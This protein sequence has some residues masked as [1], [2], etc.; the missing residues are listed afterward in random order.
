[1]KIAG[2]F[3]F[4]FYNRG[5]R[6]SRSHRM[7]LKG[8]RRGKEENEARLGTQ[9]RQYLTIVRYLSGGKCVCNTISI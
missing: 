2:T 1:M 7:W 4:L 8:I 5:T 9:F 6:Q 3:I